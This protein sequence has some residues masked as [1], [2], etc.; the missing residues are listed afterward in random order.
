[1][2]Q[3]LRSSLQMLHSGVEV[4][5]PLSTAETEQG[6]LCQGSGCLLL[7]YSRGRLQ[8]RAGGEV[9]TVHR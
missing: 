6:N 5:L 4:T 7:C 2:R 8:F 9:A 3:S 1:M